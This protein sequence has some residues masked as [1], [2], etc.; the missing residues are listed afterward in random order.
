MI[1]GL[2]PRAQ[3]RNDEGRERTLAALMYLVVPESDCVVRRAGSRQ[4]FR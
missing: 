1:E 2:G 3:G 4:S